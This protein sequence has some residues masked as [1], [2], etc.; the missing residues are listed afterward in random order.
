VG[1]RMP[2]YCSMLCLTSQCDSVVLLHLSLAGLFFGWL[3]RTLEYTSHKRCALGFKQRMQTYQGNSWS[4]G[5][6]VK[7]VILVVSGNE[8]EVYIDA[9]DNDGND[10]NG[11]PRRQRQRYKRDELLGLH[12][13]MAL[14]RRE[15]L[16]LKDQ[17]SRESNRSDQQFANLV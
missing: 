5:S 7:K 15:N 2:G 13:Q 12:S 17:M 4:K 14:L 9:L 16:Q 8:E 1:F 11:P 6:P 10:G 3:S